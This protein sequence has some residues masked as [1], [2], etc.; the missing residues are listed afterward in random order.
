MLKGGPTILLYSTPEKKIG[1][2]CGSTPRPP[3]RLAL[4]FFFYIPR[5][6]GPC[7][8]L[9]YCGLPC[10]TAARYPCTRAVSP[11]RSFRL[12]NADHER[13]Q[14]Q[15]AYA[16]LSKFKDAKRKI[17][18]GVLPW[19]PPGG[20]REKAPRGG[21]FITRPSHPLWDIKTAEEVRAG[22]EW[23]GRSIG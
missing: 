10:A 2:C 4:P 3:L 1:C 16:I 17:R 9:P 7:R 11:A 6:P 19:G 8:L 22:W 12:G 20:D 15:K 14:S 5:F 23:S 18:I 13:A 21:N